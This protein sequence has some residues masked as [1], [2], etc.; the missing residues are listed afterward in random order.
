MQL[1]SQG[2]D[3]SERRVDLHGAAGFMSLGHDIPVTRYSHSY[4]G[5]PVLCFALV[6]KNTYFIY[7]QFQRDESDELL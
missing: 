6:L 7:F 2:L 1:T 3:G 5:F 4:V